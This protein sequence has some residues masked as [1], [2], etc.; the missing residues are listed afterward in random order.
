M[1]ATS[2]SDVSAAPRPSIWQSSWVNTLGRFLALIVVFAF[3][4][5]FVENG[6]FY[7]P[8]NLEN[9]ARQSAVYATA[10]IGMTLVIIAGGID[11]SVGSIIAL[12]VV[13]MAWILDRSYETVT[14]DGAMQTG[15]LLEYWPHL[16]PIAALVVGVA[17]A[18][19]AGLMNGVLI[20][21][22]RL[23]TFIVTLGTMGIIRGIAKGIA[24][25]KDIYPPEDTWLVSIMDPTLTNVDAS[26]SWMLL[27]PGIW[28]LII[29]AVL[30]SL[31]LRYT[32]FG[33]H[34]YAIGSNEN[35]ARLCGV[36]VERTKILVYTLAGLFGGLAGIL[37]F[38]FIS[39]IGQPTTAVAYELFVIA[40]VVIG[41]GSL[42]GGE[43]SILG[44]LIGALIITILYMGGQQ[45]GWPKWVQET[46]IG[47]IIIAAVALDRFRH[48][49]M[50]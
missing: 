26:R 23:V 28:L 41:G 14:A 18:V 22:L 49:A 8:R 39:G 5:V 21:G 27:P 46:V 6:K 24:D 2:P 48:K 31:L 7:T 47:G 43:G 15:N 36:S 33:R 16:L 35:T 3:F 12:T 37:Q 11:L 13:V 4:A 1:S 30:A 10:A 42:L 29:S 40:A 32:R 38:S 20:V 34:V 9:I 19:L 17:T 25:E 50:N 45:M 44:S